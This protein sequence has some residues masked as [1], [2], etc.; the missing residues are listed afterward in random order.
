MEKVRYIMIG[1]FLGAGKT[2]AFLR[3]A[4]YLQERGKRAGLITNDQS[5]DLVDTGRARAADRPVQEVTGG[6]FCCKFDNLMQAAQNLAC[7]GAIDALIAEPVGSCT[8]IRA[9]VSYPL[10]QLFGDLYEVAPLS[11]L[12]DPFRCAQALGLGDEAR[13]SEKVIYIYRKQLEEADLIVVNKVDLLAP[14]LRASL[15]SALRRDFPRARVLEV[16]CQTGE[17]LAGWFDLLLSETLEARPAVEVDYDLYAGGEAL[18]GWLN[19]RAAFTADSPVDGPA[20]MLALARRLKKE[21]ASRGV[22]IAHCKMSIE[23]GRPSDFAAISLISSAEEPAVTWP[24]A[25]PVREG[26]LILNLRAEADPDLLRNEVM[27]ALFTFPGVSM[28]VEEIAAFRPGRPT[29][30]HRFA[31]LAG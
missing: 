14:A 27:T 23:S 28:R 8:D 7:E 30:T 18:L 20:F 22:E 4:T 11:V 9:T 10:R 21:L 3:L 29:P 12:V 24:S 19:A 1:G 25:V 26:L 16:S 2:T 17:G 13:F 31:T 6:C 15:A 5:T